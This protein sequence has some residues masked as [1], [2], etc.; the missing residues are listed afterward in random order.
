MM[1]GERE[2]TMRRGPDRRDIA[3]QSY[4]E[5]PPPPRYADREMRERE[6]YAA[7]QRHPAGPPETHSDEIDPS[8]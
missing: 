3:R 7:P 6:R 8:D 2:V 5:R 4:R 1:R